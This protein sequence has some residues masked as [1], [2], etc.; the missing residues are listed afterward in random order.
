MD[1]KPQLEPLRRPAAVSGKALPPIKRR[2]ILKAFEAAPDPLDESKYPSNLEGAA[3]VE[4]GQLETGFRQRLKTDMARKASATDSSYYFVVAFESG[5]QAT[6]ILK[7]L[8][9]QP[10]GLFVDGREMADRLGVQLPAADIPYN[11][12]AKASAKL[13]P[14]VRR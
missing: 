5:A 1:R 13:A 9:L 8:G 7:A 6:A 2:P 10:D 11:P 4:L 12:G 14:L 3:E